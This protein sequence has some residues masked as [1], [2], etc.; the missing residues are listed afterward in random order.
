MKTFENQKNL[1]RL[2]IPKLENTLSIYY[3]SLRP[4]LN[5]QELNEQQEIIKDF[6][7]PN[8]LGKVLQNRLIDYDKTQDN[9]WLEKWWLEYAY[10]GW[11]SSVFVNSNWF[12]I[13]RPHPD[14][15]T[16]AIYTEGFTSFQI[17][18]A[19]GF[20]SNFI[21]YKELIDEYC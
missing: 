13:T 1:P 21:N 7:K 11:R 4:H 5:E 2:P 6:L 12:V 10:L 15:P 18:R 8:G 9:S 17:Y 19:A 20:A 14:T 16:E 3:N